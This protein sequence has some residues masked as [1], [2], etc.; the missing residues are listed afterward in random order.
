MPRIVRIVATEVIVPAKTG[1][2]N[3]P[4]IAQPLHKLPVAGQASWS[5]QFDGLPKCILEVF[6]ENGVVGL[7][8]LYR[9]HDWRV[10]ENVAKRLIGARLEELP[11]QKLPIAHCRE[12]DGFECAI[13]DAFAKVHGLPLVELLG[14]QVHPQ[15]RV[16]AWSGHRT[17]DEVTP[18]AAR[19]AAMGYDCIKFKCDLADDVV[20]WCRSIAE[21]APDMRVILDPNERWDTPA[22]TR[23][24]IDRLRHIGNVLCLEDPIPRWMLREY[25]QLKSLSPIPIVLHVSLPYIYHGQRVHDAIRAIQLS[26]IDG[27]NFN[28]G[29]VGFQ[30]LDRIAW[31]AGLP[32]W[33]GSEIDLGILEA[34]Y[35]HQCAA[36]PS[37]T[38]PSDIFGRLIREHDLL[39]RP[40][41][42][43][44]P[45]AALPSG[46]GLGVDL[47]RDAMR[48]YQTNVREFRE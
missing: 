46:P 43:K 18:L 2:I 36:A 27:F 12:Y 7:G 8:E 41:D 32:C 28:G 1:T 47:D 6:L 5:V 26:A 14:G 29:L 45:V 16:G 40:L 24:R 35:L 15:V 30:Q 38:W 19:F 39:S 17:L 20:G 37:C 31:A 3:S 42:L 9:D 10:V 22:E 33:H 4:G 13:W 23:R 21:A 48:H 34:M 11:R 25:A 44:P